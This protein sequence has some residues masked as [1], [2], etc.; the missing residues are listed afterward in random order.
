MQYVMLV[1]QLCYFSKENVLTIFFLLYAV[2]AMKPWNFTSDAM[3][4]FDMANNCFL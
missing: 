3:D 4:V 2:T 1:L